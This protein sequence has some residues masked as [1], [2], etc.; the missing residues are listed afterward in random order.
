MSVFDLPRLHF[1]GTAWTGLPTGPRNGLL[2][3]ATNTALLD[4]APF[5]LDRAPSEYHDRLQ[6]Q[7][8]RV[9]ASGRKTPEGEFSAAKGTNFSG[10]GHFW[11]DAAVISTES[12]AGDVRQDDPVVGRSVDMWGH[13][14]EY[15]ATTFNRARVFDVDPA[16]NWTTTLMV[17]HFCFGR[18]DRSLDTGY[19]VSGPVTG[20]HPPRWHEFAP[21]EQTRHLP[22]GWNVPRSVVHQL[23]VRD[24]DGLRWLE[25]AS[26]S[27]AVTRM[28][29][30]LDQGGADGLVVQFCL[31]N[32]VPP[33]SQDRPSSWTL[34][35]TIAPWKTS[36]PVTT[37]AG[38]LLTPVAL[39][40]DGPLVLG[41]LTVD[42]SDLVTFNM[43]NAAH[44]DEGVD[45]A[46]AS[47]GSAGWDLE[48]RTN[49]TNTLI[50]AVPRGWGTDVSCGVITVAA[51]TNPD[52][53][54]T[55][56]LRLVGHHPQ[57]GT[58][59]LLQEAQTR[60]VVDDFPGFVEHPR[61]PEDCSHDYEVGFQALFRGRPAPVG[62]I[63]VS[64]CHNPRSLPSVR[65]R[66]VSDAYPDHVAIV[67]LRGS[68][69]EW[70]HSC[71]VRTDPLGRGTFTVRGARGGGCRLLLTADTDDEPHGTAAPGYDNDDELRY[72]SGSSWLAVRVLPDHWH[73][74]RIPQEEVTFEVLYQHVFAY[75]EHCYSFMRSGVFSLADRFRVETHPDLIWQMC[76][77]ENREKTYYM[78]P[79]RDL[80]EPQAGLLLKYLRQ[81]RAMSTV[82]IRVPAASPENRGISTRGA[83]VDALRHGARIELAVMLQYL[84]AAFS[85]P[86]YGAGAEYVRTGLWTPEQLRLACGDGGETRDEG[87][88]GTLLGVAREEMIHYLVVNN[89]LMAIGEPFCVPHLDFGT[90]N[91]DLMVPL[92]FSLEPLGFGSLQRF[93]QIEK[94]EGLD[95]EI[96]RGDLQGMDASGQGVRYSSLSELYNNIRDGL[97][98]V[99][100]LFMVER[101]RGG[102]EHHLFLRESLNTEHPDY[103][104]EVDDLPSALF[105]VDFVAE[106]GEGGV[107]TTEVAETEEESHYD[108]FVRVFDLLAREHD[109]ARQASRAPWE[110][111]Y[112]VVRNPTLREGDHAKEPVTDP[113][114]REVMLLFDRSYFMMLQLMVQHFGQQ[115]DASLRRSVLMNSAID[116]MTGVMRPLAELLV[117]LPSG[118]PGKTAGPS[119]ELESVPGFVSRPDVAAR[120]LQTRFDELARAARE[121]PLVPDRVTE[122]L[123]FLAQRYRTSGRK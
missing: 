97:Q 3:L 28:R 118:R 14:N 98:R 80:T 89:I 101:G 4:G 11:I 88:R 58:R 111:A 38:R 76:D 92:D 26:I 121:C 93:I 116:V 12:T 2:D 43:V 39:D 60:L 36:E 64:Q 20:T 79:S 5:P 25:E 31:R 113:R 91:G 99:P 17:G 110:P 109:K 87:I 56:G 104:L 22:P 63:R 27:P 105:A 75:Y 34:R 49:D 47:E 53:A 77:P 40:A 73:L 57:L 51:Q 95:G 68:S 112:P 30:L 8:A 94:P 13:Y 82:P 21:A 117:T 69:R 52:M 62:P 7:G 102:G 115:P 48:L 114:A 86:T 71:V 96:R 122:N 103:Q 54:R 19:M 85:V 42:V 100:D 70:S 33:Q 44:E 65:A 37:P 29:S 90:I 108:T 24:D 46:T 9:D 74:E 123:A 41:N 119:F 61:G 35:G 59:V 10:N 45:C 32:M 16:S 23:V 106:Q 78:P 72:W 1:A 55:E 18:T 107:R 120:M 50:A 6:R 67:R 15:L 83:L 66:S 81:R 84:Y